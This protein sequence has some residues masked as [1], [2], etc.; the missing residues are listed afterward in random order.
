MRFLRPLL[1]FSPHLAVLC[2]VLFVVS[3]RLTYHLQP[4]TGIVFSFVRGGLRF[5]A[6]DTARWNINYESGL[7]VE[8]AS[9]TVDWL[10]DAHLGGPSI[11]RGPGPG[12][13]LVFLPLW[14]PTAGFTG[15]AVISRM[16]RWHIDPGHCRK[17][18]YDLATTPP[19]AP[20]PECGHTRTT[21]P[22]RSM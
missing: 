16:R 20:C 21:N 6:W 1:R 17:C 12:Q 18:N 3:A 11:A 5:Y 19:D 7:S 10:P 13:Y 14:L 15:L 9:W 22:S 2:L 4:R 8:D